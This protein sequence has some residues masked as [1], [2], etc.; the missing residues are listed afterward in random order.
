MY[1]VRAN[2]P[3]HLRDITPAS[4]V[5][6]NSLDVSANKQYVLAGCNDN[7]VRVFDIYNEPGDV[8]KVFPQDGHVQPVLSAIFSKDN[9]RVFSAGYEEGVY[10]W[11]FTGDL[12]PIDLP[13]D[14]DLESFSKMVPGNPHQVMTISKRIESEVDKLGSEIFIA[15]TEEELKSPDEK[16]KRDTVRS[17]S[18]RSQSSPPVKDITNLERDHVLPSRGKVD[19]TEGDGERSEKTMTQ[20]ISPLESRTQAFLKSAKSPA[21]R[22]GYKFKKFDPIS[23]SRSPSPDGKKGKSTAKDAVKESMG[24]TS[25]FRRKYVKSAIQKNNKL[26]FKHCALEGDSR[27]AEAKAKA[28]LK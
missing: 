4:K 8:K 11:R 21:L 22:R 13:I 17:Q 6:S 26:P 28:I 12:E 5:T 1:G 9:K 25:T 14:E 7:R 27:L 23:R 3:I 19:Q 2:E 16:G 24:A 18:V 10:I 20:S 15:D